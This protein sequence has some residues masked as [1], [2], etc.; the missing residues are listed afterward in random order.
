MGKRGP[1]CSICTHPAVDEINSRIA[2]QDKL[3]A[4][5]REFAVSEDALRRH[6]DKCIITALSSTPKTRD[7]I[8]GNNLLAQLEEAR[9]KA[10]ELLDM[11]IAAGNTKIYGSP[12]S[13]L[14]EIRQQI[15][16]WAELD[17]MISTQPQINLNQVNIYNSPEWLKVGALLARILAPYPELRAQVAEE[18]RALQKEEKK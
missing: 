2:N 15:K 3:A 8:N 7:V 13:Y 9:S 11:A 4:I 17:G 6:R 10:I 16:L 1:A 12:S 5:S 18:L 14:S